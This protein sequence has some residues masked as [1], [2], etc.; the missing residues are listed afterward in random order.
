MVTFCYSLWQVIERWIE[1]GLTS[2]IPLT[3]R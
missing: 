1:A 2:P 3:R